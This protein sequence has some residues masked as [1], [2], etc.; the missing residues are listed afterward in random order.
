MTDPSIER[1]LGRIE[2]KLEALQQDVNEM[3]PKLETLEGWKL[4]TTGAAG[5]LATIISI[6]VSYIIGR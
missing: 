1:A 2:G 4:K 6:C 3:K 5:V